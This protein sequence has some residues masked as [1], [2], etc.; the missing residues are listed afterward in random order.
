[1]ADNI[2][3]LLL[4]HL[5]RFQ[6]TLERVERELRDLKVRQTETHAAIL[7]LCRNQSARC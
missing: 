7:G 1:M 3:N 4:E 2:D 5:K 6:V